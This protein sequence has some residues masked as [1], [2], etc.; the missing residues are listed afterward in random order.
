MNNNEFYEIIKDILDNNEVKKLDNYKHHYIY[1]RLEHSIS[2]SH[3]CY[4]IGKFL[5][6]NYKSLARAGL[7]HDFFLYDCEN[8]ETRPKNH[9]TTHPFIALKNANKYFKLSKMECNLILT[10]MWPLTPIPPMSL[11][12]LILT[13]VD[14]FC[15]FKEWSVFVTYYLNKKIKED[16]I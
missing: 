15:A 3:H 7:L 2:V 16:F 5:H 13:F 12:G 10:H 6:L 14:K 4:I 9:I 8:K 1:T 11:E